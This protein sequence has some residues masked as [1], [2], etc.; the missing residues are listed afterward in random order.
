MLKELEKISRNLKELQ[1]NSEKNILKVVK[2][3]E[4]EAADLIT[5]KQLFEKGIDGDGEKLLPYARLTVKIKKAKGDPFNRTTLK[6]EGDFYRG[7]YQKNNSFPILYDSKDSKTG[8]LFDQYGD[9]ILT[10]TKESEIELFE[11]TKD[12]LIELYESGLKKAFNI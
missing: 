4:A 2:R 1:R 3:N 7:V 11:I 12:E 8:K 9:K 5:E 10:H 6:D